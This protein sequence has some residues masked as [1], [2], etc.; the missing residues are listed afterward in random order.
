MEIRTVDEVY[1][2]AEKRWA[3]TVYT[4]WIKARKLTDFSRFRHIED[5]L[6]AR[7]DVQA[8]PHEDMF[9]P[10]QA[11]LQSVGL[12]YIF[13]AFPE[14]EKYEVHPMY[15]EVRTCEKLVNSLKSK[16]RRKK[17]IETGG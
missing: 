13:R 6:Y 15:A 3:Y 12:S 11:V 5:D 9:K 4:A 10:Y 7:I 17:L 8:L 16:K 1:V 2:I 14:L